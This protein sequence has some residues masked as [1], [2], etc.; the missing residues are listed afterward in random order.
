MGGPVNNSS[1]VSE[2]EGKP[3]YSQIISSL[4]SFRDPLRFA[5]SAGGCRCLGRVWDAFRLWMLSFDL[6]RRSD[7]PVHDRPWTVAHPFNS[8]ATLMIRDGTANPR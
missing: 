3:H 5:R 2:P 6:I 7:A 8:D 1:A 4:L